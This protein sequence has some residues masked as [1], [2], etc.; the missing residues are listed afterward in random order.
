MNN[1]SRP[2]SKLVFSSLTESIPGGVNSPVRSFKGLMDLPL[3]A[4]RGE[5][6]VVY[7]VDGHAYIDYCMS[8]GALIHGHAHPEIAKAA[9]DQAFRGSTFGLTTPFEARLAEKLRALVPS[10]EKVRFVS[11]GTE[12]TM[13]AIRL[14]RGFTGRKKI[15][16]FSGN[17]HGHADLLLMQG[18][19]GLFDLNP[20]ATSKG[21][22]QEAIETTISLP[23][24]DSDAF[25]AF[26]EAS[27]NEVA[28]VIV[29]PVAG[30]MGVVPATQAFLNTLREK[31]LQKGALLIFDEVMTG[32]RIAK[33][34]GGERYGIQADLSCYSK[35]LGGGFPVGAFGG[36]K[37]VMDHLAP[38]GEVYQAG[39]LSGNPVAMS[40]GLKALELLDASGF[41]ETL[42]EKSAFLIDPIADY[43]Q[44]KRLNIRLNRVGSMFTLFFGVKEVNSLTDVEKM[45]KAAF[46]QFFLFL[47][48]RGVLA[49]PSAQE[50]WFVS[51][52]HSSE[53]LKKTQDLILEFLAR[54]C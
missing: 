17:Y 26:M 33:G 35:I 34:G 24:N 3:V 51:Q 45:D 11:S 29:E 46:K 2:K 5:G 18:G 49:P 38:L 23:Y 21:I 37:E 14:A 52:A 22:P 7:D 39:T 30:N 54:F 32:F 53:Q 8:W 43:I 12:A 19:S 9:S 28:A 42:E 47:F 13:S 16:K 10:L 20:R 4:E 40:A 31:T 48:E 6:A 44:A 41:Y 1:L 25:S 50:A 27:G 15:V 36:K